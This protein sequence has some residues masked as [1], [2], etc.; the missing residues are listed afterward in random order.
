M[1]TLQYSEHPKAVA[2][3]SEFTRHSVRAVIT[4]ADKILL[5]YTARYDDYSLPG[6]GVDEGESLAAAVIREVEEETGARNVVI[7][8]ELGIYHELRPWYKESHDNVRMYSYCY[9]C[10]ADPK[11]GQTQL[12]DY[13]Q[14]NGMKPVWIELEQAIAHNERV[15]AGSDKAGLSLQRE[16]WLMHYISQKMKNR[17]A[18]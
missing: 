14:A 2:G 5:L 1:P 7:N 10:T 17:S 3:G 15:M 18:A 4:H 6:G 13:E 9:W 11:L 16:T 8:A 12:E